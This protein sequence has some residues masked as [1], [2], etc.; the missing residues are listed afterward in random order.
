[1]VLNLFLARGTLKSKKDMAAHLYLRK[2]VKLTKKS[3]FPQKRIGKVREKNL[4][5]HL[6]G[7]YGT[8]VEKH[9]SKPFILIYKTKF[10]YY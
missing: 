2:F 5:A 1:V 8:P 4:A 9:C 6:E 7:V 3:I 10:V